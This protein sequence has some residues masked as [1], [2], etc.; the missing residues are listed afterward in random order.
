ML[1]LQAVD[2]GT[3]ISAAR[4]DYDFD[5]PCIGLVLPET[6]LPNRFGPLQKRLKGSETQR[7]AAAVP[8]EG[9]API[10]EKIMV[11]NNC[12]HRIVNDPRNGDLNAFQLNVR[13]GRQN[14]L[15]VIWSFTA[16]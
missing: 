2:G 6:R 14:I 16:P 11:W 7:C 3:R 15:T 8:A 12:H 10:H 4:R 9:S 1:T 5:N 13:G